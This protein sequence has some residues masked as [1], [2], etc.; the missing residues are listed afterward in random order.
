MISFSE[1]VYV[2]LIFL[3]IAN[4]LLHFYHTP[5]HFFNAALHKPCQYHGHDGEDADDRKYFINK[6]ME[7][8]DYGGYDEGDDA[9]DKASRFGIVTLLC[10]EGQLPDGKVGDD[11]ANEQLIEQCQEQ[12]G[13]HGRADRAM[14]AA[15]ANTT[16]GK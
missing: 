1:I 15:K 7:H 10:G 6:E 4:F 12:I 14:A 5:T 13:Q 16:T 11:G 2:P 8:C 3:L 9:F